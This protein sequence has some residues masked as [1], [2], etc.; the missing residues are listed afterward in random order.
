MITTIS[1]NKEKYT[2][3][4]SKPLDLSIPVKGGITNVNAWYLTPPT[5]KPVEDENW[6]AKVSEG[7]SVNFNN[8]HFNP[9]S[10][11]THT[12]SV[13][14]ITSNFYDV[15]QVFDRYF[16]L[17]EVIS[18]TPKQSKD[19]FIISKEILSSAIKEIPEALL[20]RTLPN[21]QQKQRRHY[22]HTNWPFLSEHGAQWIS[23]KNI[24]HLLIDLPSVDKEKDNGK[25]LAHKA[26]W[27]YPDDL[28]IKSTITELIYIKDSIKDGRYLLNL[29]V[30]PFQNDAAPSRPILY[31][32]I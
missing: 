20:I 28:R 1:Y 19:D 9:H 32:I 31:K 16:F 13:G 24:Q 5:I 29:Q 12:E 7:A 30:A 27:R 21:P 8:I 14:H 10:H 26:F 15:N 22:S 23:E 11:G 4:L 6:I 18:V 2:I 25:L 17:A 3:D